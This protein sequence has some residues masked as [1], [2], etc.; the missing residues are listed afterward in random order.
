MKTL[1]FTDRLS[2]LTWR[3]EWKACYKTLSSDIRLLK[4]AWKGEQRKVTVVFKENKS[5]PMWS[6]YEATYE[7]KS[8]CF[9]KPYYAVLSDL[10]RTR[11]QARDMME[12]LEQA[13]EKSKILRNAMQTHIN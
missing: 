8:L 10:E 13:K 4:Q 11:R 5:S 6:Y 1:N 3:N 12:I 9:S 7:G 2:Y